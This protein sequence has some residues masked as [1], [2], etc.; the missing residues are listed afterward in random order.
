MRRYGIPVILSTDGHFN[1]LL[2]ITRLDPL[3]LFREFGTG[4][5]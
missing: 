4:D 3:V 1:N 5:R 2:D